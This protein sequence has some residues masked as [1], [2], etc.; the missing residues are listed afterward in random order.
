ME[1]SDKSGHPHMQACM[2]EPPPRPP[3]I[4]GILATC[5]AQ[6]A[7][8]AG[9]SLLLESGGSTEPCKPSLPRVAVKT[10]IPT[11]TPR[12]TISVEC[13]LLPVWPSPASLPQQPV[14]EPFH[15][16]PRR[17]RLPRGHPRLTG[18]PQSSWPEAHRALLP[19]AVLPS[20]RHLT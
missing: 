5:P 3:G 12:V 2:L 15:A 9:A 19:S 11:P 14:K 17:P 7:I 6:Q 10:P 18:Q 1:G 4:L 16:R 20:T 13:R 8:W